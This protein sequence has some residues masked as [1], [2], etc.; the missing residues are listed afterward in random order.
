MGGGA[1]KHRWP[2]CEERVGLNPAH[3]ALSTVPAAPAVRLGIRWL[4]LPS[5]DVIPCPLN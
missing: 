4:A 2:A 1:L 3:S 5:L